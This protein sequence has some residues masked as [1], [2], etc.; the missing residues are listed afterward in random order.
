MRSFATIYTNC[1]SCC[2]SISG[3]VSRLPGEHLAI[4]T[5]VSILWPIPCEKLLFHCIQLRI[6]YKRDSHFRETQNKNMTVNSHLPH[7]IEVIDSHTAG[8]PTRAV[9]SGGPHLGIGP[10]PERLEILRR[11]ISDIYRRAILCEP[12]G[13]DVLVGALMV[14]PVNPGGCGGRH[15]L[16][17][18]RVPGHVRA[19]HD[20]GCGY[21]GLSGPHWRG[22]VSV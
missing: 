10:I 6:Q 8:E 17:Q 19:W 14:E 18:C 2:A 11:G 20:R 21:A 16:Q 4:F 5:S 9:I 15:L 22:A 13:S 7:R 3:P 1:T 12:R